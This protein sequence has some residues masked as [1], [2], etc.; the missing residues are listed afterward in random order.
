MI[1]PYHTKK[2]L[3]TQRRADVRREV[4]KTQSSKGAKK[5]KAIMAM[6][7]QLQ[8]VSRKGAKSQSKEDGLVLFSH[9]CNFLRLRVFA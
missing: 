5:G 2:E 9:S 1:P 8:R 4:A 7:R 3:L 6:A